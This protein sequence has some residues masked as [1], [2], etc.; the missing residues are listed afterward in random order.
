MCWAGPGY[1]PGLEPPREITFTL[2]VLAAAT[3]IATAYVFFRS[4]RKD[5][6]LSGSD[7]VAIRTL[8][9]QY[10]ERD[11]LGYFATRRDKSAD[12]APTGRQLSPIGWSL[13]SVWRVPIR[14]VIPKPGVPLLRCGW[15]KLTD[16]RG[17]CSHGGEPAGCGGVQAGRAR[18]D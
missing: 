6:L 2:S 16:T 9:K 8:L 13:A 15:K 3:F 11:S 14:W 12:W 10:G 7:E 17:A 5:L 18:R 4:R 1:Q